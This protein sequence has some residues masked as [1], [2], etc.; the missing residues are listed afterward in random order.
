K[1]GYHEI[2]TLFQEIDLAD[3]ILL[4]QSNKGTSLRVYGAPEIETEDNIVFKALKWLEKLIGRTFDVQ[5]ELHKNVPVAAGL[6]GGSGNAAAIIIGIK[7]LFD[8]DWLDL[9]AIVPL[10]STIGA[11]VPFFFQGGTAIGEGLGEKL[12]PVFIDQPGQ[13][14]LVNPGFPV[15]TAKIFAQV[16]KT[17]TGE[18][19]PGILQGLYGEGSDLR[20]FLYNELQSIAEREHPSIHKVMDALRNLGVENPLM[21]GSGPTVFGF[22][23]KKIEDSEFSDFPKSWR[24]IL[25][26]PV[27]HGVTIN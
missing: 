27:K 8:L 18:M 3:E 26:K 20:S 1:D 15:S 12:T 13:I 17:L 4:K 11:D 21:S 10:T 25:T 22:I 9:D 5:I 2:E 6:G 24:V 19:R 16:S 14:L 23:D 7:A